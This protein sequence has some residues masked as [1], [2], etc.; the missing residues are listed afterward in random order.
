MPDTVLS[1]EATKVASYENI[2]R[3]RLIMGNAAQ[4]RTKLSLKW[5]QR[6]SQAEAGNPGGVSKQLPLPVY[7]IVGKE[8]GCQG[9]EDGDDAEE[10]SWTWDGER[11]WKP[12]S[13]LWIW[14]SR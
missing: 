9:E 3:R 4:I 5:P 10:T 1:P 14:S 6:V 11:L 13:G 12:G 7:G 8:I 2:E